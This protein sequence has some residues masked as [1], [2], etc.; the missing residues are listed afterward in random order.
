MKVTVLGSTGSI[1]TQ[2]LQVIALHPDRFS[3]YALSAYH[4]IEKLLEQ[5]L[6]FTPEFCVVCSDE[7]A[8]RLRDQLKSYGSN[9]VVLSGPESLSTIA[10]ASEVE[11]VVAGIVGAAGL[12]STLSAVRAGKRVL[13]ANKEPLVMAGPLFSQAQKNSKAVILPIDSEHNAVFQ[14]LGSLPQAG[15]RP[16]NVSKIQ[17]TAS[18]GP[19]RTWPLE[20][21]ASV[22]PEQAC[23]HPRWK[24]GPKIS[25]DCATMVNK[26]LEVIE[27]HYLFGVEPE[28]IE[29]LIHPQSVVHS[30]V[31]FIDGSVLAQ[32]G[33]AD[34]RIPIAY[35]LS[36]PDRITNGAAEISLLD[37][38]TL[39]FLPMDHERYPAFLLAIE[40][41]K[42]GGAMP[43]ILNAANE[44]AVEAFM[45]REILF[46]QIAT[47]IQETLENQ[48]N[49]SVTTLDEVLEVDRLAR[50]VAQKTMLRISA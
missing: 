10:C 3:V 30:L 20:N 45:R 1:G 4:N 43:A 37:F 27:A 13:F 41:L 12:V 31:K 33:N 11:C 2:T 48:A 39:E 44:V 26:G 28:N 7:H 21:I 8:Y 40:A 22:T 15:V 36:Y 46:S 38:K 25:I 32:L 6:R 9:T 35:G 34:M 16:K 18:G 50:I 24:M 5:C 29:V 23:N 49:Q 17:L 19:F 14:C 42:G 47:V